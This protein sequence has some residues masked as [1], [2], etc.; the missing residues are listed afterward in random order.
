MKANNIF[1]LDM[2]CTP[3]CGSSYVQYQKPRSGHCMLDQTI[4]YEYPD[5]NWHSLA[6]V[7][8]NKPLSA[9]KIYFGS[10]YI[11]LLDPYFQLYTS[12]YGM[13]FSNFP[14]R[15]KKQIGEPSDLQLNPQ[16]NNPPGRMLKDTQN[17]MQVSGF[18]EAHGGEQY[19][20]I[21]DFTKFSKS[22]SPALTKPYWT[23]FLFNG[24]LYQYRDIHYF[25]DDASVSPVQY[26]S[27]TDTICKGTTAWLHARYKGTN[28]LWSDSSK[29]DS[30]LVD[31][32]GTYTVFY[33]SMG[34]AAFDSIRVVYKNLTPGTHDTV[35]CKGESY[36]I[37]L[38][39]ANS[40]RWQ[41]G[42]KSDTMFI[43]KA[44]IYWV[45]AQK[46]NCTYTDTFHVRIDNP[47]L[48]HLPADTE[49]CRG[50][51][52]LINLDT[53][54]YSLKWQDGNTSKHYSI[55]KNGTYKLK[56]YTGCGIYENNIRV[57]DSDC[58]GT[59]FFPNAFSPDK[60]NLNDQFKIIADL[61]FQQ[62][63]MDIYNRWG[64]RIFETRDP[65]KGWDGTFKGMACPDGVYFWYALYKFP[66]QTEKIAKGN[67]LLIRH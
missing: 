37:S 35:L 4:W 53:I 56:I 59:V 12:D 62:Y 57:N 1:Y 40:Y 23:S 58:S 61:P 49:L 9:N 8:L 16:I 66:D 33:D 19:I 47:L 31:K 21:G 64:E 67:V 20:L 32:A 44:G 51:P 7:K 50:N 3:D 65:D 2:A 41:N 24:K 48:W 15:E 54:S 63:D 55:Q 34:F 46:D 22:H 27:R 26:L 10:F 39:A 38:P 18:Y 14:C 29:A 17:W 30:F 36:T 45:N 43:H 5:S 13:Y 25:V 42:S 60:D 52:W 28:C 6:E 11:S